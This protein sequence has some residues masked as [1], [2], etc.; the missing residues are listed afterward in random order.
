MS[1]FY[2][3]PNPSYP[4][5]CK[6]T[7]WGPGGVAPSEPKASL[8]QAYTMGAWGRSPQRAEGE[9]IS[10]PRKRVDMNM[11]RKREKDN[12]S[13]KLC[14]KELQ[15]HFQ[16]SE[17]VSKRLGPHSPLYPK[18]VLLIQQ[19]GTINVKQ[20]SRHLLNSSHPGQWSLPDDILTP[21]HLYQMAVAECIT[22]LTPFA[23]L[24]TSWTVVTS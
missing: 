2:Q 11:V 5:I 16:H 3:S 1:D 4:R 12:K 23:E 18:K 22:S 15:E 14:I 21:L 10:R 7:S 19:A 17:I 13:L 24:V 20:V 8:Y 9:S 6:R